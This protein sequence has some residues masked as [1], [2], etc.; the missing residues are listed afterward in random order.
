MNEEFPFVFR[1]RIVLVDL[2]CDLSPLT[3]RVCVFITDGKNFCETL[4]DFAIWA[5]ASNVNFAAYRDRLADNL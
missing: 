4:L 2:L 5:R 1:P 3:I